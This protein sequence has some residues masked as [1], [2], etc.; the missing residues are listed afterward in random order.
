M[1]QARVEE[2]GKAGPFTFAAVWHVKREYVVQFEAL[3]RPATQKTSEKQACQRPAVADRLLP[4]RTDNFPF[5]DSAALRSPQSGR[6]RLVLS[7]SSRVGR[8]SPALELGTL[9][10]VSRINKSGFNLDRTA[11]KYA[12]KTFEVGRYTLRWISGILRH[13]VMQMREQ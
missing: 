5:C 3:L 10:Q 7:S 8:T 13:V 12:N 1:I 4:K 11:S 9:N 6:S 2:D